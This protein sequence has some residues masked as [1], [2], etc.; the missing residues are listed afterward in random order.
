MSHVPNTQTTYTD[1]PVTPLGEASGLTSTPVSEYPSRQSSP[2]TTRT[3]KPTVNPYQY[4][5]AMA[6]AHPSVFAS[7]CSSSNYSHTVGEGDGGHCISPWPFTL[8]KNLGE[9]ISRKASVPD[10]E[11]HLKNEEGMDLKEAGGKNLMPEQNK[12]AEK[13]TH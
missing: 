1:R 2:R 4:Q 11:R 7:L 9:V 13:T 10:G 8:P 5:P 6:W 3:T 12:T